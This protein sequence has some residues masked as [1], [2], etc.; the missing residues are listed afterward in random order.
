MKPINGS[1]KW[2]RCI[3]FLTILLIIGIILMKNFF[4]ITRLSSFLTQDRKGQFKEKHLKNTWIM[5]AHL[6]VFILQ[7][8]H[9]PILIFPRTGVGITT[10]LLVPG[11]TRVIPGTPLLPFF[12]LKT[13]HTRLQKIY[14]RPFVHRLMNG[15]VGKKISA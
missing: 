13:V 8:F 4:L 10:F 15:I 3:I 1:P 14:R 12:V 11:N 7:D 5:A 6:S 9:L 2:Q